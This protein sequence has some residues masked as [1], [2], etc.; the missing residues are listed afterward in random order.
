[1]NNTFIIIFWK[2]AIIMLGI[3]GLSTG[4]S[5]SP[6]FWTSYVLD[7]V[8]PAWNYILIRS[9]YTSK[10]DT[11]FSIKFSPESAVIVI[12]GICFLVEIGQYFNLYTAH[13]DPYDFLAYISLILPCYILDK[14]ILAWQG[15]REKIE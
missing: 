11:F 10:N 7:M 4:L 3:I 5:R 14:W 15:K 2:I 12:I 6:G 9:I 8:G 13:F 1:M